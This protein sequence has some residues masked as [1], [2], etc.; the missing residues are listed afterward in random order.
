[1][2]TRAAVSPCVADIVVI[3]EAAAFEDLKQDWNRLALLTRPDSVFL[4]HEWFDAAWQWLR[5]EH[6]L[7][8]LRVEREGEVIGLCPLVRTRKVRH[9][10]G[11]RCLEFMTIPD[12]QEC[13][14]LALPSCHGAV[15]AAMFRHLAQRGD[16]DL[17]DLRTL[18][19]DSPTLAAAEATAMEEGLAWQRHAH[20]CNP[21]I[22]LEGPW[23]EY[24]GRRSRR[25]KKGNNHVANR[26]RRSGTSV[27]IVHLADCRG[28]EDAFEAL[29]SVSAASWKRETGL[30]LDQ[31]GPG[32]FIRR[33]TEHACRE[34]WASLWLLRLDGKVAATEYQLQYHGIVS[35]LRADFDSS[36]DEFSPGT[37]LNW[38][39]LEALFEGGRHYYAMGPGQND[40]KL[41][42]AEEYPQLHRFVAYNR[43]LRGR[44]LSGIDLYL[45]PLLHRDAGE[46]ERPQVT[47]SS[48][49][50]R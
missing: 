1:M 13:D 37:Y 46:G 12:T 29:V 45:K 23:Q 9:R 15:V 19:A 20:E 18:P 16:W 4:R 5:R 43:T 11:L 25:L 38:K 31:P 50:R 2:N 36:F 26:L 39:I 48:R 14:I 7:S 41:R 33:L 8:V 22:R 28:M 47:R 21:G 35:A 3:E 30:T 49:R 10:L 42:W 44:L 32:A 6:A 27:E 17:L 34:G 24:Y 40:Y